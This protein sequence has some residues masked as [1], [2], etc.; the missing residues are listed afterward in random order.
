VRK[1]EKNMARWAEWLLLIIPVL[2]RLK[3][4][5]YEFKASLGYI[6]RSCLKK[7]RVG[8]CS[9]VLP[10]MYKALGLIPGTE[11]QIKGHSR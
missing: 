10:T 9:L 8:G 7:L 5:D 1:N 2:E 11:K 6:M 3:Q 4:E